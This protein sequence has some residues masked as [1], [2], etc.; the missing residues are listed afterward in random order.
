MECLQIG[1]TSGN[2]N[3]RYVCPGLF[4]PALEGDLDGDSSK[5]MQNK[6][7]VG[8]YYAIR[9]DWSNFQEMRFNVYFHMIIN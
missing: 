6:K 1:Y 4:K 8:R 7:H 3:S 2:K 9:N 5:T